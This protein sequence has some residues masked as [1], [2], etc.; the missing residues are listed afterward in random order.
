MATAE[1][2][3]AKRVFTWVMRIACALL[4]LWLL[5]HTI[6]STEA[7]LLD[8]MAH[9]RM[10]FLLG[11]AALYGFCQLLGAWRWYILLKAQ[12]LPIPLWS[13]LR[14]T[15]TGN[16][17]SLL[18]PGAVTG[19]VV[20]IACVTSLHPGCLSR[21]ATVNI[22]DRLV[23]LTGIF[24]AAAVATIL[25][26]SDLLVFFDEKSAA[27]DMTSAK[28]LFMAL[29]AVNL[30][31]LGAFGLYLLYR[32]FPA[33]KRWT[34][35]RRFGQ[36]C[37]GKLPARLCSV[38]QNVGDALECYRDRQLVL[39][40][41]LLI[42]VS[43]HLLLGVEIFLL[44]RALH[45]SAVSA[46]QYLVTTQLSNASGLLAVTPGGIG[47]RDSVFALLFGH[48]GATP[49]GTAGTIP[50]LN[51]L[52]IVFWGIAGALIHTFSPRLTKSE[53]QQ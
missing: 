28:L 19:D 52:I 21:L 11:A 4:A 24:A 22:I 50:L 1:P 20:K 43:I 5:Q 46:G 33:L 17:F 47:L 9:S 32:N 41:V 31:C 42:S 35:V 14:L 2:S 48:F 51:S 29:A 36:F 8:A 37:R 18:T 34:P 3:T 16:F 30:G 26:W 7:D 39:L 15:L 45:E 38:L 40:Q 25:A 10:G 13:A 6:R 53:E 12:G 27:L 44:G 49:S 23:G